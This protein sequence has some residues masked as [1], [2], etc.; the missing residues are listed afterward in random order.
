MFIFYNPNPDKTL[1]GDCVVRALCKVLNEDWET[2]AVRLSIKFITEHDMPWSCI[3]TYG[4]FFIRE[5]P[6][7]YGG[8]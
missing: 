4:R 2:V 5:R 6:I 1:V 7:F 8:I 3:K